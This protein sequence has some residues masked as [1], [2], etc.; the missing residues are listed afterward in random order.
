MRRAKTPFAQCPCTQTAICAGA[1]NHPHHMNHMNH[2]S[3]KCQPALVHALT[4]G[5]PSIRRKKA[6]SPTRTRPPRPRARPSPSHPSAVMRPKFLTQSHTISRNLSSNAPASL[7]AVYISKHWTKRLLL[8]IACSKNP[9]AIRPVPMHADRDPRRRR[10]SSPSHKLRKSQFKQMPTSPR[11]CA[12]TCQPLPS[13]AKRPP[14]RPVSRHPSAVMRP[15]LFAQSLANSRKLSSNARQ[16]LRS[17]YISKNRKK[18]QLLQIACSKNPTAIPPVPMHADRDLRRRRR[19]QSS[20]SPKSHESQFKQMSTISHT[21]AHTWQPLHPPQKG[22]QPNPH[23]PP[24]T[25]RAAFAIHPPAVMRPKF[26]TQSHTISRNLSSNAPA[27]LRAVYISKN[28][29]KRQLLQI[30]CSKNPTAIRPVPMH[31]DRDPRRR[32]QSSPSHKLRKS[33]FKQMPTSP[34]TC[35]P[36]SQPLHPPQKGHQPNPHSPPATTRAAFAIHP[37]A[38]MRPKFLAQSHTISRNLP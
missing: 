15:K 18:R 11:T 24:A 23:S 8:Q 12:H 17:V 14:A 29:T 1:V 9:T 20:P 38:V 19:L 22:H 10:Q 27:S 25:T 7:R 21:C 26:L 33:Q 34:R 4:P 5:N 2:S 31:A 28:R 3:N 16:S 35:A 36:A 30:A 37:S 6:T 32:R 13:A